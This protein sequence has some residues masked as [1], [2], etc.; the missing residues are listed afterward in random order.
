MGQSVSLS[1]SQFVCECVGLV[2]ARK[3]VLGLRMNLFASLCVD[4]CLH[5]GVMTGGRTERATEDVKKVSLTCTLSVSPFVSLPACESVNV[6][7]CFAVRVCARVSLSGSRVCR[8]VCRSFNQS[9][10]QSV[11]RSVCCVLK[12]VHQSSARDAVFDRAMC[13]AAG[14]EGI[15]DKRV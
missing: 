4:L 7:M 13:T 3:C 1:V 15:G 11:R 8:R 10:W 6:A 14:A 2:C 9:V 12:S 5:D